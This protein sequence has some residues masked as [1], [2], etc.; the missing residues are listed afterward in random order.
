MNQTKK[1]ILITGAGG[2]L[3]SELINQLISQK[4][5]KVIGISSKKE[6]L[7]YKFRNNVDFIC[8][9]I[10]D[11]KD[12][13]IPFDTIDVLINCAF[14]KSFA[15]QEI[16]KSLDFTNEFISDAAKK[17]VGAIINI[18]SQS[19]YSQERKY[20]ANEEMIVNPESLYGM[21]KYSSELLVANICKNCNIPVTNIRL[22]SLVGFGSH[23]RLLNRFVNQV[24]RGEPIRI[25][26]GKQIISYMDVR[27]ASAGLIALA[28]TRFEKWKPIYNLG[29]LNL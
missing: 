16:A 3:G 13:K 24:I 20:P 10:A 4:T 5:Y 12:D 27:D 9:D 19:V 1:F 6:K 28:C 17:G 18:S 25:I 14:A 29:V 2:F 15:G 8:F 23:K 26:G 11:W 7:N 21:A 22:A